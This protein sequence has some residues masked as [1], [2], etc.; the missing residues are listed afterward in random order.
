[1]TRELVKFLQKIG[2][3]TR[4]VSIMEDK[5]YINNLKFSRFSRKKEELFKKSF[6]EVD[7][8][9]SKIFQKICMRASRNLAHCIHPKEKIFLVESDD[10]R[11]FA[12]H[13][14]LEPYQRKYGIELIF[15]KNMDETENLDVDSITLPITLDDEAQNILQLMLDGE[16]IELL[17]SNESYNDIKLIYPLINV[18][19]S[20]I[21]SWTQN[22]SDNELNQDEYAK[23]LLKFLE[24]L[25][26]G[27][28]ENLL[29]SALFISSEC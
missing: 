11:N 29:K 7:V 12:I 16:K 18:P 26:P 6:P 22:T 17:S 4:F 27:V 10:L 1:M 13:T 21:Y 24:S 3:D 9:R 15:G 2:V 23:D 25:V 20:W 5:V 19:K 14:I 8:I 28:R